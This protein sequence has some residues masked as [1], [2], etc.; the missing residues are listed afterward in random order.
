MR[1]VMTEEQREE[2]ELFVYK[3]DNED[4]PDALSYMP[5]WIERVFPGLF[6]ASYIVRAALEDFRVEFQRACQEAGVDC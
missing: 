4:L 5:E 6:E 1:G 2:F 3:L